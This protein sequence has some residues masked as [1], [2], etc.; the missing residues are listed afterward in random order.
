MVFIGL[1][2]VGIYLRDGLF[3]TYTGI[4]NMHPSTGSHWV[5]YVNRNYLD[6]YGCA[7]PQKLSKITIKRNGYCLYSEYKKQGLTIEKDSVLVI[8]YI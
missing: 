5:V 2:N 4:V 7:P 6:S 8:V 1:D 3:S